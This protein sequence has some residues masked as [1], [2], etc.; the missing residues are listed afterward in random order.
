MKFNSL[1]ISRGHN[2]AAIPLSKYTN[3]ANVT[4]HADTL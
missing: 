2:M 3:M 4:S 1:K